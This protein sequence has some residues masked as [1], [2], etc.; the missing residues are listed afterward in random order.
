MAARV[1]GMMFVVAEMSD[2]VVVEG[3][4]K[5]RPLALV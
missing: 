4:M 2:G 5:N 3:F 1:L